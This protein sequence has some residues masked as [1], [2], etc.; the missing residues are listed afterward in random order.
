MTGLLYLTGCNGNDE[1]DEECNDPVGCDGQ[2]PIVAINISG[3]AEKGPFLKDT[4]ITATSYDLNWDQSDFPKE[5]YTEHDDGSYEIYSPVSGDFVRMRIEGE[6]YNEVEQ[7]YDW[8]SLRDI[9]RNDS[10]TKNLNPLT[11][12]LDIVSFDH[13]RDITHEFYRQGDNCITRAKS[14]IL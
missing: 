5:G 13:C 2:N 14:E 4:E 1:D 9:S 3:K 10:T 8:V 6:S 7:R 12:L 11:H